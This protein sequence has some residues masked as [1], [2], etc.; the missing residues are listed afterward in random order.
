MTPTDKLEM[1]EAS[2]GS[3]TITLPSS[4]VPEAQEAQEVETEAAD[5]AEY[6][7]PA[8]SAPA[9]TDVDREKLR[10]ARRL[11]R[12]NKKITQK[13]RLEES[14]HIIAAL[15]RQNDELSARLINVENRTSGAEIA[16]VDKSIEDSQLRV[17]YA[18]SKIAE[19]LKMQD[20]E[21]MVKAQEMLYESKKALEQLSAVKQNMLNAAK[22]PQNQNLQVPDARIQKNAA[23]WMQKHTW[24]KPDL[25][26]TDSKIAHAID[27]ELTSEG[28]DPA[29]EEYWEELDDRLSDRMPNRFEPTP[30]GE[31]QAPPKRRSAVTG[32]GRETS[33]T[34]K[35]GVYKLD[36]DRVAAMKESGAWFDPK[37]KAKM[38]QYYMNYDKENK[39]RS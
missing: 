10:E 11:E 39:A 25:S 31:M 6:D 17:Q 23:A 37:R 33:S 36:A 28:W 19:A 13:K 7:E 18:H 20:G 8:E 27:L 2:D 4:E 14:A 5:A 3:A 26:N 15:K 12:Q 21:A 1:Q 22:A 9:K 16:R 34:E 30:A 35:A 32:S 24:Y 38:V 29:T